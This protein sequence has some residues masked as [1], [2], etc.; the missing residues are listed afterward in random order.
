MPKDAFGH[1][2]DGRGGQRGSFG[3]GNARFNQHTGP[4]T[5]KLA[6]LMN[7]ADIRA[8]V[9]FGAPISDAVAA[10]SLAQ[11]HPKSGMPPPMR[12]GW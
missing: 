11:N 1:G 4:G 9:G 2:S 8:R 10:A 3:R 12:K 7:M 5:Q 6:S